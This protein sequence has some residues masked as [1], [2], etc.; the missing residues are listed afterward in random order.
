MATVR[1]GG[2][3]FGLGAELIWDQSLVARGRS[4]PATC[5]RKAAGSFLQEP[6]RGA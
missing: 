1:F 3:I 2:A 4:P 6:F 5:G